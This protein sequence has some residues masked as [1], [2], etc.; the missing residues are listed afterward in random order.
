M[1]HPTPSAPEWRS[2]QE[3][4]A[5]RRTLLHIDSLCQ[6]T[7]T[8]LTFTR[9]YKK[10]SIYPAN[11]FIS[12]SAFRGRH[13]DIVFIHK[14]S[15]AIMLKR[16][17]RSRDMTRFD[18]FHLYWRMSGKQSR[19]LMNNMCTTGKGL[20]HTRG[21]RTTRVSKSRFGKGPVTLRRNKKKYRKNL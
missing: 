1:R 9:I 2:T 20:A 11:F 18:T 12:S 3:K 17:T 15:H 5:T 6:I 21:P 7:A 14:D 8:S 19:G 10:I 13:N 16:S 4:K